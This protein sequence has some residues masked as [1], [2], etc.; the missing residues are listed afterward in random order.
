MSTKLKK[1]NGEEEGSEIVLDG[2]T[3]VIVCVSRMPHAIECIP[4]NHSVCC[5]IIKCSYECDAV[6]WVET[7]QVGRERESSVRRCDKTRAHTHIVS[8]N[9]VQTFV[10]PRV[11]RFSATIYYRVTVSFCWF[12]CCVCG[13]TLA[14]SI[15]S[16]KNAHCRRCSC[17][18]YCTLREDETT[19]QFLYFRLTILNQTF[20]QCEPRKHLHDFYFRSQWTP[21]SR[22]TESTRY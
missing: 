4:L 3:C 15:T 7:L 12:P 1:T 13:R 19:H 9:D 14:C 21:Q 16:L 20:I 11:I 18:L 10:W 6:T 2:V 22:Y 8:V 17:W 5:L